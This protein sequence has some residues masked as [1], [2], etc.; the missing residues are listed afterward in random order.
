MVFLKHPRV[1]VFWSDR[2]V[3]YDFGPEH[4]MNPQRLDLTAR[5]CQDLGVFDRSGVQVVEPDL[6]DDVNAFLQQVHTPD[7]IAAVRAAGADP[8][9]ADTAY[10]L[11][12]EDDPAFVGMHEMSALIAAGTRAACE[13]VWTGTCEHAVNFTGGLHHAM[14]GKASGFCIYNDVAL[15]I[16]WLLSHGAERV[17]YVDVDVH[18]GDGVERV[19]WD[20]PRVMT[21]SLHETGRVLFPG[22]GFPGDVGGPD[23]QGYA[24]NVALP[25]GTGDGAWLRAFHS[26]VPPLARAFRPQIMVTQQGCDSHYADPLAHLA[27]S[28]DA[29]RA[30][31]ETLHD[32][33]HE[34]SDG[35]W[36]ALGG[37]GYELVDVVPRAW[38]H[39]TAIATHEPIPLTTPVPQG[40]RDHVQELLGRPGPSRMG[41]GVA[42][43]GHVWYRS[44]GTGV[45]P[46]SA[47]D[48][49]V[50]ATRE[51]VF[52]THGLD[53]WFD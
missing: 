37:G 2:L 42:Q 35:K 10:G 16:E 34:V 41:D 32:L 47:L 19:F 3:G 33:A 29:Q 38:T 25:P 12:T 50:L 31:Y 17:L 26:I 52:P 51:A 28:I 20:D 49:A 18:H 24:V 14:P 11:G 43:D 6:P 1:Q 22:T 36:V 5:L 4:P 48:R 9:S 30:A 13:A 15:G 23:A 21:I 53:V 46:D 44:W 39:L 45:D 40:W 7:Y 8:A 27:L